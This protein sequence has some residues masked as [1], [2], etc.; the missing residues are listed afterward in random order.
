MER[1]HGEWIYP[2]RVRVLASHVAELLP[3]D[4]SVLDVGCG[5]A[6]VAVEVMRLRPDVSIAGTDVL[7]RPGVPIEVT[8][9][10]GLHL[11]HDDSSVDV[12]TLVDVVHHAEDPM[13]LLTEVARVA[14]RAVVV[15]DHLLKGALADRTLRLMD[16]VG[17]ERHGVTVRYHWWTE[18]QWREAFRTLGLEPTQWRTK[19]GIYPWPLTLA[20]DRRLQ[21]VAALSSRSDTAQR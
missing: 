2:R 1:L 18:P 12:V 13:G 4:S 20:F 19:L 16:S 9:F 14:R 21:F 10:D 6:E 3:P 11:P 8:Q 7:V 5:D 15:K 17:N